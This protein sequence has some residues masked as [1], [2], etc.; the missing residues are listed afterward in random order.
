ME[1]V[2]FTPG[3]WSVNYRDGETYWIVD[4]SNDV[5]LGRVA[6]VMFHDDAE[7]E[8]KANAR[9]IKEAPNMF[10]ALERLLR[11]HDALQMAEGRTDDRWSAA[12][13]ARDVLNRIGAR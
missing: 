2:K 10:L 1:K 3:P 9:L 13:M 6:L 12:T 4:A 5:E 7:N 11:E 8:T